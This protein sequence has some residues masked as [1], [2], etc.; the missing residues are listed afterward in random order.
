MI[1]KTFF[2][3][4]EAHI[5]HLEMVTFTMGTGL[6]YGGN[7]L[8]NIKSDQRFNFLSKYEF[9]SELCGSDDGV[10]HD[11]MI[12]II[13]IFFFRQTVHTQGVFFS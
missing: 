4:N 10:Y 13:L 7:S 3:G 8:C 5:W 1:L 9:N 2:L 12:L 6:W 11:L